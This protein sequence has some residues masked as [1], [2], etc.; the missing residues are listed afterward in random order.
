MI[1]KTKEER[2]AIFA[3][4]FAGQTPANPPRMTVMEQLEPWREDIVAK[5]K[6]GYSDKQICETL[7]LDPVLIQVSAITLRKFL[8]TPRRKRATKPGDTPLVLHPIV[9][10]DGKGKS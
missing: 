4:L 1:P 7:K 2:A 3:K 8:A 9:P 10:L 6:E 5:R